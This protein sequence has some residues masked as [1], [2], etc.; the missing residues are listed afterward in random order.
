MTPA[1][2]LEK[3]ALKDK[4]ALLAGADFWHTT[5]V[6]EHGIPSV[7]VA[8]GSSGIRGTRWFEGVRGAALPNGTAFAAT[9][10]RKLIRQAGVLLGEECRAK[11]VHCWLGPTINIQRSPLGGRGYESYSED[12]YL[13]GILAS[14]V[15]AGCESTGVIA[16]IKHFV[17]NDQIAARDA[18]AG[19]MMA[20]Y[21]KVNGIHVSEDKRLLDDV[22]RKEWKWNPLI[23]SDWYG[24]YSTIAAVKAGLDLEMPGPTLCRGSLLDLAV[25][26]QVVKQSP[27]D[28]R[29]RRVLEFV[30]RASK[31]D[32][33]PTEQGRDFP[34]DR[35]L[36]KQLAQNSIVLLKNE[37]NIFPVP[38]D[39]RKIALIGSHIKDSS[40]NSTGATALVPYYT[41]HPYKAILA[42]LSSGTEVLYEVGAHTH[43]MLPLIHGRL[44]K[45]LELVLSNQ[46]HSDPARTIA[47]RIPMS[48]TFF[49]LLDY[50]TLTGDFTP[51]ED[52]D[53]DFGLAVYGL[54]KFSLDDQVIIDMT[55][56]QKPGESFL[57]RGSAEEIRTYTVK[58]GQTYK[59]H[60]EFG[61][62]SLSP[63]CD[64]ADGNVNFGGGGARLGAIPHISAKD[65]IEQAVKAASEAEY[66]VICTGLSGEWETEG[67]D[68]TNAS[69]DL[70]TNVD[71]LIARV[72][73]VN[74]R[75]VVVNPWDG[76]NKTGSSIADVLFGDFNPCGKMPISWPKR[77]QDNPTYLNWGSNGGR[78]LFGEDIFVG[79]RWYDA[80][81]I[82]P[83]WHFGQGL[84]YTTFALSNSRLSTEE[85]FEDG[86]PHFSVAVTIENS[87]SVAGA[88][89]LQLYVSALDSTVKRPVRE[90]HGFD[91]VILQPGEKKE[92]SIDLDKYAMSYWD[93]KEDAWCLE[94]GRYQ[95]TILGSACKQ[96]SQV[97]TFTN[98]GPHLC[99]F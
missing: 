24:T 7:R 42:K 72:A 47:G 84:S 9:W 62:A 97:S 30:D 13:T 93:E 21:N 20:S 68:R 14:Q 27:L 10:D 63:L 57:K 25:A 49:Q 5:A 87:G 75:T 2:T 37:N 45:D 81:E 95:R 29:A 60:I 55:E 98:K 26:S 85:D 89:V 3:L 32:V 33:S 51:D 38:K 53:W 12:P 79:Y 23:M 92:V 52:G 76:G 58:A 28:D 71:E 80:M 39:V 31:I 18:P 8:D 15:I 96:P 82:K 6:P 86:K 35:E 11:G 48:K 17:C 91:K 41:I 19:A 50:G 94:K 83:L 1:E 56:H 77:L 99:P 70:P 43:K 34:E 44:I 90:L 36:N 16:T 22:V 46:R 78:V 67:S 73:A 61:T 65:A 74:P 88:E 40:M 59:L 66:A 54:A 64:L 4:I 69:M